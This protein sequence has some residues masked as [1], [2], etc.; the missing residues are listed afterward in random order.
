V[1]ALL[2]TSLPLLV[3]CSESPFLAARPSVARSSPVRVAALAPMGGVGRCALRRSPSSPSVSIPCSCVFICGMSCLNLSELVSFV[4]CVILSDPRTGGRSQVLYDPR[5]GPPQG[6][7]VS[8]DRLSSGVLVSGSFCGSW[9]GGSVCHCHQFQVCELEAAE[10]D[11]HQFPPELASS[12]HSAGGL[13]PDASR[14]CFPV[15][16]PFPFS[17]P[18]WLSPFPSPL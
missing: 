17:V 15:S 11:C 12:A 1:Y 6:I 4:L 14:A 3:P 8:W 13:Q 18:F 5:T 9:G 16:F 2:S 10:E 7:L